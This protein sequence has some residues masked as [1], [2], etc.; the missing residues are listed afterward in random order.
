MVYLGGRPHGQLQNIQG[1]A[2][3]L[4]DSCETCTGLIYPSNLF[5]H[6]LPMLKSLERSVHD[7]VR[8]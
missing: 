6:A 2:N 8:L 4:A 7:S 3:A 1:I 5:I